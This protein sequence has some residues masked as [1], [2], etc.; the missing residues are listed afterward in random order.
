MLLFLYRL[1]KFISEVKLEKIKE[2]Y[3]LLFRHRNYLDQLVE[4]CGI[5]EG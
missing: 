1:L 4:K 3:L 5:R 2:L